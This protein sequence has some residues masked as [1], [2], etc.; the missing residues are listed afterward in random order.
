MWEAVRQHPWLAAS[1]GV[2]VLCVSM[3]AVPIW[4]WGLIQPDPQIIETPNGTY[5][6]RGVNAAG[7][8][9]VQW[10]ASGLEARDWLP[11]RVTT[12]KPGETLWLRREL[13]FT[14]K[15]SAVVTR[16]LI[17]TGGYQHV[18]DPLQPPTRTAIPT[19]KHFP[20]SIPAKAEGACVYHTAAI[21]YKNP[22]QW[23]VRKPFQDVPI[24]VTP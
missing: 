4:Y 16:T 3:V 8:T 22:M 17:C 23:E 19:I 11:V 10:K 12:V 13:A 9:V 20:V 1:I 24:T 18:Y 21:F 14:A 15:T 6:H 5:F 2:T 7:Q